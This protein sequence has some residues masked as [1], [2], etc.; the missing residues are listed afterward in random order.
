MS[1]ELP[2]GRTFILT[3]GN[4]GLGY[5]TA[6]RLARQ[7]QHNR[8]VLACRDA[9]RARAAA[10]SVIGKSGNPNVTAMDLDLASV[11]SVRSFAADFT[12]SEHP[13]LYALLCNAGVI[14]L[15]ATHYTVDGFEATFG[16]NHLGHFLL[17]AL[18]VG[19]VAEGGRIVFVSSGTHDPA[20][21]TLVAPPVYETAKLLASPRPSTDSTDGRGERIGIVGQRRYSTSKLCNVYCAY[22]LAERLQRAG[23]R[24]DVN[25]F[26]PGEMPGTGFSRSFPAPLRFFAKY[27]NY[28][29]V[30]F[31]SGVHTPD[32]S[33]RALTAIL[34]S[35]D[36]DG[37]TG[38]YF[39]GTRQTRS[40]ELS[41]HTENRKELWSTSVALS[42]LTSA[43]TI[44]D[45]A[46]ERSEGLGGVVGPW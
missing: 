31:R 34:T 10:Q 26:D 7:D 4:S 43:E 18:L 9:E 3:G 5:A 22:E 39:D 16:I 27:V 32:Q 36:F 13:P 35:P 2:E 40:S 28:A 21:K 41:Y 23:K 25:A 30:P 8:L 37:I 12:A 14:N 44:L 24:I 33:A 42:G 19:D 20:S 46:Y 1:N 17:T 15:D 29:S 45:L 38:T 6:M 11:D